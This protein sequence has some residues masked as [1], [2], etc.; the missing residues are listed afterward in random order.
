MCEHAL[1]NQVSVPPTG[2]ATLHVS[3]RQMCKPDVPALRGKGYRQ[4]C[5]ICQFPFHCTVVR[6]R[7]GSENTYKSTSLPFQSWIPP[8]G[9]VEQTVSGCVVKVASFQFSSKHVRYE[10]GQNNS[11]RE[12]QLEPR[13]REI[14]LSSI[15]YMGVFIQ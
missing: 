5:C 1:C 9:G 6:P 7:F 8:Q 15:P 14:H 4:P 11:L 2:L 13:E 12:Q 10:N 3:T